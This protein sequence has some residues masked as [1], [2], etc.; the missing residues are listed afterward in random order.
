MRPGPRSGSRR[1]SSRP[2]GR[3]STTRSCSASCAP[4][5]GPERSGIRGPGCPAISCAGDDPAQ[6]RPHHGRRPGAPGPLTGRAERLDLGP[7]E[8]PA[9]S[10]PADG[11][12]SRD[13]GAGPRVRPPP[14]PAVRGPPAPRAGRGA[15][16]RAAR[17]RARGQPTGRALRPGPVHLRPRLRHGLVRVHRRG[18]PERP[19]G[20]AWRTLPVGGA[21]LCGPAG[22]RGRGAGG[23]PRARRRPHGRGSR[24]ARRTRLTAIA[25]ASDR[26]RPGSRRAGQA[27]GRAWVNR[28]VTAR[29][30]RRRF[31]AGMGAATGALAMGGESRPAK[32]ARRTIE[33]ATAVKPAGSDIGAIEHV[34]LLMQENRSF[35][36]YFGTYPGVRG[37]DDHPKHSLAAFSQAWPANTDVAPVGRLLPFHLDTANSNAECTFDLSHAWPAQHACWNNGAMDAW[38]TTH[39][40]TEY[41]GPVNGVLTMGYY[42]RADLPFY[43]A[44]ADAFTINDAYHCSVFGP[45]D[46]NRLYWLSGTVDPDGTA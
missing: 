44:L 13:S 26:A 43:Y 27:G 36:H 16:R 22:P 15:G 10:G 6:L 24:A 29:R 17:L 12:R 14:G 23:C 4:S 33:A 39:T 28:A 25:A 19:G 5:S 32:A 38:V 45:T 3:P 30:D 9:R 1:T 20:A 35:D 21:Q 2:A 11:P 34:V 37:F 41:E 46:P 42:T 18:G 40:S 7:T 8:R 31:L